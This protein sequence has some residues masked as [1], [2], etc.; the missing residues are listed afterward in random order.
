MCS[1]GRP[2]EKPLAIQAIAVNT[3]HARKK[4]RRQ[5]IF[6]SD[7]SEV[8]AETGTTSLLVDAD[9]LRRSTRTYRGKQIAL[10]ALVGIVSAV[11]TARR[12]RF[13]IIF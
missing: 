3:I 6:M 11:S 7:L 1:Y 4:P 10:P 2:W 12:F 13:E 5:R 8:I 9:L